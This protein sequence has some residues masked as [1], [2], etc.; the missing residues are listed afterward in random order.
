MNFELEKVRAD[1]LSIKPQLEVIA[2]KLEV[3]LKDILKGEEF[4]DRVTCRV[5]EETSFMNKV[6]NKDSKG[7]FKY[8]VPIKE[9]QDFIGARIIVYYKRNAAKLSDFISGRFNFIEE[10][11]FI[12]EDVSSFG[13]EGVHYMCFIPNF[14]MPKERNPLFPDFF[15]LQIKTLY[16]HAWSQSQHGLGYKPHSPLSLE[17][18][19]KL[20]FISAQSWGADTILDELVSNQ[21]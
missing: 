5:K 3:H 2:E 20:A 1:F 4:I 13:Y 16:Q 19:R 9:I 18:K 10:N 17:Q 7:D 11:K 21:K 12:P 14:L 8:K 15:E 6:N